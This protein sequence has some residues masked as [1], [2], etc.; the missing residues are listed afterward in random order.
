[1]GSWPVL[2]LRPKI[3]TFPSEVAGEDRAKPSMW[4]VSLLTI[5]LITAWTGSSVVAQTPSSMPLRRVLVLHSDERLLPANIIVDEAIRETFAAN[6]SNR[7]EFHS[8]FLDVS[9]FPGETQQQRELDF[10]R[11]KYRERPPDL[12]IAGG[13]PALQFLLKY[14]AELFADVPTVHCAVDAE[15]LPKEMPDAKI[16]GIPMLRPAASTLELALALQPDTRNVAVVAGSTP[17][18]LESAEQFR[19]ETPSFADRVSF[20]W[21]TNLSL[22]DL[23]AELSR[24]PDHTLVL[25]LTMFEDAAGASFTHARHWP[26]SL[27]QAALRST[28]ATTPTWGM[29]LSVERW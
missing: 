22:P 23:R 1:M 16:A 2:P 29:G 27:R 21:L 24:L 17:R 11:E 7:I 25:Y 8:E 20:S 13:D 4:I 6:S 19:R 3:M 15:D 12:V 5:L 18:D 14:R 28:A 9:R 10:L 26:C